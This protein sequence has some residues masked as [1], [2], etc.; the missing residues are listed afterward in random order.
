MSHR[1]VTVA[2][3]SLLLGVFFAD[4][5]FLAGEANSHPLAPT[6]PVVAPDVAPLHEG[7]ELRRITAIMMRR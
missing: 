6:G 5:A 7:A 2:L 4:T 1:T 3:G